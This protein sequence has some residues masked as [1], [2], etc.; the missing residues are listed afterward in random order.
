MNRETI[1]NNYIQEV[2]ANIGQLNKEEQSE[3]IEF[4]REF[5]LDSNLQTREEINTELGSSK[6]LARKILADYSLANDESKIEIN[7]A[8]E[9]NTADSKKVSTTSNKNDHSVRIIWIIILG[10]LAIPTAI[11]AAIILLGIVVAAFAAIFG[12][13]IGYLGL[14]VG[15]VIGGAYLAFKGLL[16]W[17]VAWSVGIF[18]VGVGI[19]TMMFG[20]IIAPGAYYVIKWL[21][22]LI[23]R[24]SRFIGKK[25]FNKQYYKGKGDK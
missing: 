10:L 17:G 18:Y 6:K 3:V 11:P 16:I 7:S 12:I 15:L 8:E 14:I 19:L 21:L 13:F 4:Y 1:I 20:A 22:N 23:V 2:Q 9:K 5:L 25:F 24:F